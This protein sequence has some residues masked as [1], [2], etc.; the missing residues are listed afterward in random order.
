MLLNSLHSVNSP[1]GFCFLILI[2]NMHIK[3]H[4]RKNNEA[5]TIAGIP[6]YIPPHIC[7]FSLFGISLF[8]SSVSHFS[9]RNLL[10]F[11]CVL[12][13]HFQVTLTPFS[14][15]QGSLSSNMCL[16]MTW[17][18]SILVWIQPNLAIPSKP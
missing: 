16:S 14:V 13:Y 3:V 8:I 12:P 10:E 7:A 17:K 5:Q 11:L 1:E 15:S 2:L 9:I 6:D 18:N 4:H